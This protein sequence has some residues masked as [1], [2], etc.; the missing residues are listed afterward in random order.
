M[1]TGMFIILATL[2]SV[3]IV[4]WLVV[5]SRKEQQRNVEKISI[6]QESQAKE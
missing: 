6:K 1:D 4:A 5:Y 3:G 2:L